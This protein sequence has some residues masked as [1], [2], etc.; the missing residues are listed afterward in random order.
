M[1]WLVHDICIGQKHDGGSACR[2]SFVQGPK[3][4]RPARRLR[5][6]A[7]YVEIWRFSG[8]RGGTVRRIIVYQ[9]DAELAGILLRQQRTDRGTNGLGFIAGGNDD[10]DV[11]RFSRRRWR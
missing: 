3:L 6:Q 5:V 8:P 1:R 7:D 10:V 11:R 4:P 9:N 2:N